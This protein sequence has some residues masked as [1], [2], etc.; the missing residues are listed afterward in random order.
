MFAYHII[1]T[2][3]PA[4]AKYSFKIRNEIE[5]LVSSTTEYN[6]L[7]YFCKCMSVKLSSDSFYFLSSHLAK[8]VIH[9]I[10][11]NFPYIHLTTI[12]VKN[13]C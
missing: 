7:N 6:T 1:C 4:K 10:L 12:K 2:L 11:R 5:C 13:W 9:T 8:K 3:P